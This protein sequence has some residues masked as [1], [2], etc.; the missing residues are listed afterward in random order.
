MRA[1]K[2]SSEAVTK[3]MRS[4]KSSGTKPELVLSKLLRKRLYK[5]GLPGNPDFIYPKKRLA[6]FVHGCFWH[7]CP[8]CKSKLPKTNRDF[9]RTKF[10]KNVERDKRNEKD[11]KSLGWKVVEIWEHEIERD[12]KRAVMEIK[13]IMRASSAS[14]TA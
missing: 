7:R 4:N 8:K 2:A 1:P 3:S 12:P 14:N 5:N 6:V 11:L 13:K 10:L 9:W